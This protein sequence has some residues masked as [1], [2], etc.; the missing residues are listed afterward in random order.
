MVDT[1]VRTRALAAASAARFAGLFDASN[2][3]VEFANKCELQLLEQAGGHD[4]MSW[5]LEKSPTRRSGR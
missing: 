2:A 1:Q 3:L 5:W 4:L